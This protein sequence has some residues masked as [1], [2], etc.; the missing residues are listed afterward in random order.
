M[1]ESSIVV[2]GAGLS[3]L[4]AA[5]RLQ[6]AG[7][8]VLLL[9]ARERAGGRIL[10]LPGAEAATHQLD[11]GPSWYWPELNPLLS[12]WVQRLGL[13]SYP[14]HSEGA[15]L[16]EGPDG[17]LRRLGQSWE[18]APRSMRI[19]G[20]M[21]ALVAGMQAL[22]SDVDYRPGTVVE[23]LQLRP[24][25]G[26]E[27]LLRQG[28]RR[29][30]QPAAGVISTLP[31]RLLAEL[32]AQPAWPPEQMQ[33]WRRTPTWMA[34][35]AKFVAVYERAFWREAGLSGAAMSQRGPMAEIHDASSA[36]GEAAALFGFVGLPA[37]H[38]QSMGAE[39]L[40]Q[41]A[42]AQL[43]RLFGPQ[44]GRPLRIALQDWASEPYTA[45]ALDHA[46]L[47]HHPSYAPGRV[48]AD[49]QGRL[50]LAGTEFAPQSGGYLEGALE[51]AEAAQAAAQQA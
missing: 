5:W 35:Q 36:S 37:A 38:R 2:I 47:G 9:E 27:L 8:A 7:R 24:E 31:P 22:L 19:A 21:A 11:L 13:S 4:H 29:D 12:A 3:G 16:F 34:G 14:Q 30:V 39:A 46:P 18:Q 45:H 41:Q 50:W 32:P 6:A 1:S 25:G 17:S 15:G 26:V 10:S 40:R 28:E 42:L 49:W 43:V 20:G 51:A 48:P 33:A 23:G 44:A